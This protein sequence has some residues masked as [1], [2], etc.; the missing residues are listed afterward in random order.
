MI[1]ALP[2]ALVALRA[3]LGPLL[4]LA[5]WAGRSGPLVIAGLTAGFLSDVFDGVIAR[6]L[7]SAT[8]RL[9]VADSWTDAFYYLC[10]GVS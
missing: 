7:G 5:V 6:L 3:V 8:E 9:R 4:L 10:L 2:W 1:W